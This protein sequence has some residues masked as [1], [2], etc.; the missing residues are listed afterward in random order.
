MRLQA[1][2]VA[3]QPADTFS[4][5][6]ALRGTIH[7]SAKLKGVPSCNLFP[8]RGRDLKRFIRNVAAKNLFHLVKSGGD[9]HGIVALCFFCISRR[10]P[11]RQFPPRCRNLFGLASAPAVLALP[12]FGPTPLWI[13]FIF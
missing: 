5:G 8:G 13:R 6:Y 11:V 9:V 12:N 2:V 7:G 4:A 3:G 10:N 1:W